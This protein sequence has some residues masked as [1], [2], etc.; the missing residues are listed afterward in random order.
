MLAFLAWM[1]ALSFA[2]LGGSNAPPTAEKGMI[3]RGAAVWAIPVF[4]VFLRA[5]LRKLRQD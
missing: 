2:F 5:D 3:A 4:V 1:V